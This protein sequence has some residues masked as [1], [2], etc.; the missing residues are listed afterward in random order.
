MLRIFAFL[1]LALMIHAA[2]HRGIVTFGGL[3]V[4]GAGVTASRAGA[5]QATITDPNGAYS[6]ADLAPGAWQ[7]RV[8]M[9]LFAPQS[10]EVVPGPPPAAWELQLLPRDKREVAAAPSAAPPVKPVK[11]AAAAEPELAQ[12][13]ADGLLINGSVNNGAASP[14]AQLPAFGNFRRGARSM[15]NGSLGLIGNSFAFDARSYSLTGQDTPKPSYS[16]FQGLFAFGGPVKIPKWLPRNG[17]MFTVNYQWTRN[18]NAV[19]Q[20]GLV[21]TAA[22]RAGDLSAAPRP[23][24]DPLTNAPFPAAQI[25][26]TRISP[27]ARTLLTLFPAPNF[28]GSSRYNLQTP[29]VTGLHQDDFQ[30][31]A[32][33]QR[34]KNYY[35]GNFNLQ[36]TRTSTPNL[37]GMLDTTRALGLNTGVNYRRTLHPRFFVNLGAQ[38]SRQRDQLNPFFSNRRNIAAEAGIRGTNQDP[39]HWGPPSLS[40]A[41][42]IT[43]LTDAQ[44]ALTRNQTVAYNADAFFNH[45]GHNFTFGAV[46]RRQQVNVLAQ[47]DARGSF[48]FTG[49]AAGN[50]VAG[51]L[52][53]L[54]DTSSIAFGNA[55]KY[56]RAGITEAFVNDD[57]RVHPGLTLNYGARW[58]YWSPAQEKYGRL[59]N[60]SGP[61]VPD[62]NNIAPRVGLSWR[63]LSASSLVIRAGYGIY[64]D[65]SVYQPIAMQMAQQ[66]PFSTN[67]RLS[68]SAATPLT[69][70]NGFPSQSTSITFAA[71]P[72]FR[73]GYSQN[74]QLTLQRDLPAA[75]QITAGYNGG[76][77]TRAQQQVLPNT[78]PNGAIEPSGY[79]Y[80]S[81]NGNSTRH[82]GNFQLRRRLRNGFTAQVAYTYSKSIDNASPG[83]RPFTAQNWLDLGAERGRSNFDQRHLLTG[84]VQY[85]TGMGVKG[86]AFGKAWA[87]EWTVTSQLNAGSGLPLTPIYLAAVRGTGV[88][89]SLRP[90]YTGAGLYDAPPGLNLNPAA[91]AAPAPGRWGNAGRN[92]INGPNQF[93]LAASL[94]RTFRSN[95]RFSLDVRADAS[96]ALN[97]VRFPSWNTVLGNAQFGLPTT[98]SPMRTLQ[99]TVRTRF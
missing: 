68:N 60:Q 87:K 42:G 36:S 74:W 13:A 70:A 96:N 88:T 63:P 92:S 21:P 32:N 39:L 4:P 33:K 16:R 91:I 73:I 61:L 22:E 28:T 99:L 38:F 40:F 64:Y 12:R 3:P 29:I 19:T 94:G 41:S 93:A 52:L 71:D 46:H 20:S 48:V 59:V 25:P 45:N 86:G 72:R 47:Q 37:Y 23:P 62:K 11:P 15:Y 66:A 2:E 65:T 53:G 8:D 5:V 84:L 54:P 82:A 30:F 9:Q 1:C 85:T 81:S 89:G 57:W 34:R 75:L 44:A 51:F 43:P 35:S 24:L 98:A 97:S 95:E 79:T 55:D 56:L 78:F 67:L 49:A 76:K 26:A 77:G 18:T 83:G 7:I 58:E 80:L 31:R 27:Q 14:F 6:F 69:I 17:P 90:D 10:R 50:D